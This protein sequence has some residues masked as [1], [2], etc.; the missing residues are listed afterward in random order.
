MPLVIFLRSFQASHDIAGKKRERAVN[1]IFSHTTMKFCNKS[2]THPIGK[3]IEP[4]RM[5]LGTGK[6]SEPNGRND[7]R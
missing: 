5:N 1:E 6:Q 7:H 2:A 3:Y 4:I